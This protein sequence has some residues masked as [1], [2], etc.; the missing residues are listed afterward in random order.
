MSE[1]E[2]VA[3]IRHASTHK[4]MPNFKSVKKCLKYL[5]VFLFEM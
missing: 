2:I 3:E 5:I 4:N 1:H